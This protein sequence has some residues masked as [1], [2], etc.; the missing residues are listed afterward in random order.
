MHTPYLRHLLH[1]PGKKILT[2]LLLLLCTATGA[3]A[4][5]S[6]QQNLPFSDARR[7]HYGFSIG[8]HSSAFRLKYSDAFIAEELDTLHSIMPR[9]S[10][11]F[12]LGFIADFRLHDQANL[13]VLPKV[14]FYEFGVDFNSVG[15]NVN[16][17]LIEATYIELPVMVKLKTQ[18][19]KNFRMY[20][21]GGLAPGLEVSG[22][23]RKELTDNRLLTQDFNLTAEIG[24]G[25][26]MYF[27]LFK[28]SPEIRL[29]RGLL[30][31]L[32]EDPSGYSRGL[33]SLTTNV[34][35]LYLQ[36]S[37]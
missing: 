19:H 30:N 37:D 2:G 1:L 10:F 25:V 23:K 6:F 11:G 32:R 15:G 18:R 21:S 22:K 26:D 36:F 27:P 34:F 3:S 31:M 35:T 7:L 17:Q 8:L 33:S 9:N 24:F 28:F 16:T 5:D 13:R 12:S 14:S 29:S 4:Q 20:V